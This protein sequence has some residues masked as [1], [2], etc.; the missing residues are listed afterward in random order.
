MACRCYT[1]NM[2]DMRLKSLLQR[3]RTALF[4]SWRRHSTIKCLYSSCPGIGLC[5]YLLVV[6][7]S[8]KLLQPHNAIYQRMHNLLNIN[9]QP[10]LCSELFIWALQFQHGQ[11]KPTYSISVNQSVAILSCIYVIQLAV[12]LQLDQ[13]DLFRFNDNDACGEV[14]GSSSPVRNS[15]WVEWQL[16]VNCCH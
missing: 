9:A 2:G 16:R 4:V 13:R 3:Y 6:L 14:T 8:P 15:Y 7:H 1:Y 10:P 11:R 12:H 5:N